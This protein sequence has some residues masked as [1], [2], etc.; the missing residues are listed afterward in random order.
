M[1]QNQRIQT[2]KIY[3][4]L[5]SKTLENPLSPTEFADRGNTFL[6]IFI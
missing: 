6:R 1:P 5:S 3:Q 4:K 2:P